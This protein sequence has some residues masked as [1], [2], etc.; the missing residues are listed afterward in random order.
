MQRSIVRT[1]QA[2]A[3]IGP[4]SQAVVVPIGDGKR[5][6]FCS[7]QVAFDPATMMIVDGDVGDQTRQVLDNLAAVLA[8]AGAG[9]SDIVKTTIFLK[10]MDDFATVNAVYGTRFPID[11]P[12]RAT[13]EAARLPRDV[14]VEID[15]IAVV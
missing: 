6:I 14:F 7:G 13:V 8:A 4:Y 1:A 12:A 3:A 10:S 15:A 2:P 11:P 5:M 9:F